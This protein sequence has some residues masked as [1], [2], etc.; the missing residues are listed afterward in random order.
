MFTTGID[1]DIKTS[2]E[3]LIPAHLP[4][5]GGL[6]LVPYAGRE[7]SMGR[8]ML[9]RM[10]DDTVDIAAI[11]DGN[12]T[13]DG[14]NSIDAL[15]E[16]IDSPVQSWIIQ[17]CPNADSTELLYCDADRITLLSGADQAAVVGA[18]RILKGFASSVEDVSELPLIKNCDCWCRRTRG[19]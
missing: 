1:V 13:L 3:L 2:I 19:E 4:V 9:I 17:P 18:Y 10:H 12:F 6:W 7:A 11:G 14:C 16:R 15:L 8:A 5:Q